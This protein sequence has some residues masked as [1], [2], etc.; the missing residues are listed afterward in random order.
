MD[1]E[2]IEVKREQVQDLDN[3]PFKSFSEFKK[4]VF[5]NIAQ[6][7]V[8]RGI[9]LQWAQNGKYLSRYLQIK[10]Y[11]LTFLPYITLIIF[12]IWLIATK[13]WLMLLTLPLLVLGYFLF[14]PAMA[15][16]FGLIRS[17]FIWISFIGL[18]YAII[19]GKP[20][21]FALTLSLTLIWYSQKNVYQKAVE[22]LTNAILIHEDLLCILWRCRALN[23]RF[24]NGNSYWVDWKME[25]GE[26]LHYNTE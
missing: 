8:D 12:T 26:S 4:A 3:F 16:A 6:P 2:E 25:D 24:F 13:N 11:L 15:M 22:G 10:T 1:N 20:A 21:L 17:G 23:I 7:G 14:H 19:S 9:A 5:E 18:F